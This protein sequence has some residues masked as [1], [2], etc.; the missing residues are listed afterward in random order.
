MAIDLEE[1]RSELDRELI[2]ARLLPQD[3]Y[4]SGLKKNSKGFVMRCPFHEDKEP[5]FQVYA[6]NKSFRCFGCGISGSAFD[7][8]MRKEGLDFPT[9]LRCIA[10]KAGISSEETTHPYERLFALN[11]AV[12]KI[13]TDNLLNG[14]SGALG[15]LMDVRGLTMETIKNFRLGCANGTSV[16]QTLKSQG[17]TEEEIISAGI[18]FKKN[19]DV[20]DLFRGRIIFPILKGDRILGFG[21]RIFGVTDGPKYI[22]SPS[23]PVFQKRSVLYGLDPCSI[24]T[25]GYAIL[26]EGYLDVI[27]CHRHGYKNAVSLLGTALSEDHV[28]LLRKY[29]ETVVTLFDGDSAGRVAAERTVKL[30]FDLNMK[31]SVVALSEAEDPDSFLRKKNSLDELI[32]MSEPFGC[33]LARQFPATRKMI[34]SSLMA[35]SHYEVAE[36][37]SYM[38]TSEESKAYAEIN[39]R[40]MIESLLEEAPAIACN[41]EVEIRRYRDNLALL[42]EKRFVSWQKICGDHKEQAEAMV[43]QFLELKGRRVREAKMM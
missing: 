41:G 8:V 6:D 23:T 16:I 2:L 25:K 30:L 9:A 11:S 39:A 4:G 34:I 10:E 33:F 35:R 15:Y 19:G 27:A 20:R 1:R 18:A 40:L 38:G 5:S 17:F 26:V 31:G 37:I 43:L 32:T 3:I 24:Q 13:Y 36:F 42:S 28:K 12:E 21:G 14:N 29:T 22:N 7:F